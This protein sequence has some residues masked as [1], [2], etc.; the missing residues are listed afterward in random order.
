MR[1]ESGKR[2]KSVKTVREEQNLRVREK[3]ERKA[4]EM[5]EK[6]EVRETKVREGGERR[7]CGERVR[8]RE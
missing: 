4:G 6:R 7:V 8:D 5:R 1:E 3:S 2:G